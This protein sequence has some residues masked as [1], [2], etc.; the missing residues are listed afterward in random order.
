MK[1]WQLVS[2]C[3]EKPN[4]LK[5]TLEDPQ[6]NEYL[7]LY[8][9]FGDLVENQVRKK[10]DQIVPE[11]LVIDV[12]KKHHENMYISEGCLRL[13]PLGSQ[14]MKITLIEVFYKYGGENLEEVMERGSV[15]LCD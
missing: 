3:R 10:L 2:V 7:E 11:E 1:F 8:N 14:D 4:I 9:L 13:R 6:W 15:K 5:K 12:L